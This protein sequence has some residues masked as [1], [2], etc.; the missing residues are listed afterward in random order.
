MQ[1]RPDQFRY[2]HSN[3]H[4]IGGLYRCEKS[5]RL[6]LILVVKFDFECDDGK[7]RDADDIEKSEFFNRLYRCIHEPQTDAWREYAKDHIRDRAAIVVGDMNSPRNDQDGCTDILDRDRSLIMSKIQCELLHVTKGR[8]SNDSPSKRASHYLVHCFA[9]PS[10]DIKAGPN[11]GPVSKPITIDRDSQTIN[12][13]GPSDHPHLQVQF[14][15]KSRGWHATAEPRLTP[16]ESDY[17]TASSGTQTSS[18]C[19]QRSGTQLSGSLSQPLT[20][21]SQET[22]KMSP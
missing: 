18:N 8:Q 15:L 20:I 7:I 5:K 12:V 10:L 11:Y 3:E 13:T 4:F 16:G 17:Y 19:T 9:S 1:V 22:V 2:A 6:V 14:A 21:E